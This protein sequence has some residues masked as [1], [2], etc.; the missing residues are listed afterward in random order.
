MDTTIGHWITT[1][2]KLNM[3]N[4]PWYD[5][6]YLFPLIR[7]LQGIT[8]YYPIDSAV[9]YT[10]KGLVRV[11]A[12]GGTVGLTIQVDKTGPYSVIL[13]YIV[14]KIVIIIMLINVLFRL[15]LILIRYLYQFKV[16][17]V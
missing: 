16:Q 5:Y 6:E 4:C 3:A 10:G 8:G 12:T 13:R 7:S 15:L 9:L 11:P 2:L 14:S 17:A 1:L